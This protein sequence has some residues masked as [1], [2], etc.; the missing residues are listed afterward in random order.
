MTLAKITK[1][2]F[3]EYF[4]RMFYLHLLSTSAIEN[5]R[6]YT[7]AMDKAVITVAGAI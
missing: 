7:G 5:P 1:K 6:E 2:G 3:F 4:T